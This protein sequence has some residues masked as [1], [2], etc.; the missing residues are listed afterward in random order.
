MKRI[1]DNYAAGDFAAPPGLIYVGLDVHNFKKATDR[2]PDIREE[3]FIEGTE[4]KDSCP[5]HGRGIGGWF[6]KI[7]SP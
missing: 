6:K 5:D 3:L 1:G 4:P 7:F 2:C